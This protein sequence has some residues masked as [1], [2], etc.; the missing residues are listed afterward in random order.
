MPPL[1][2][3]LVRR[4]LYPLWAAREHPGL[5][6]YLNE[7][8]ETQF[9]NQD[10]IRAL[11]WSRLRRIVGFAVEHCAFYNKRFREAGLSPVDLREPK[12]LLRIPIL[13]KDDIREHAA[14]LTATGLAHN[15][16]VDN[17]TG[18]STGAPMKFKVSRRR[19]ASRKAM[20][21]RHDRWCGVQ[22]GTRVGQ[23]WGHPTERSALSARERLRQRLLEPSVR[24]NTFDAR[25]E[26]IDGFLKS[27]RRHNVTHLL[28]YS[29]SLR[30]LAEYLISQQK[31]PPALTAAITTAESLTFEERTTIEDV[32]RCPTFDRYGCREF[33]VVAS[34]CEA[35]EGLHIAAETLLVEFVAGDRHAEPGE[36]GAIV[37]TDLL[38]E[39]MPFIRYRIGDAGTSMSG[40]CSCGRGLPRM[41]MVAGRITDFIHTPEGRWIS[42]VAIN[43]YLISQL[44]GVRQAQIIQDQCDR[45]RFRLVPLADGSEA[46]R[47]FLAERV[48][49]IFGPAMNYEIEWVDQIM[50]EPSGKTLVTM[51]RCGQLHGFSEPGRTRKGEA[52]HA[53]I[54]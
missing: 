52:S 8:E 26:N 42:G 39:A 31:C 25:E 47:R 51:S 45:L 21:H 11:Q 4:V 33:S 14:E 37:V 30:L 49:G 7:Y 10:R 17:F 15:S 27:L 29:R 53:A 34:Q 43:T 50:P 2:E 12:D 6:S 32:L 9:W 23:L 18:G 40:N 35:R 5:Y 16:F 41:Q 19:W 1:H 3:I 38:N 28:A 36:P 20:T 48:P 46:A 44:S 13:T 22:I 24:L 54:Q